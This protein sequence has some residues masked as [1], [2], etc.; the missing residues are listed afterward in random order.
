MRCEKCGAY[1][2]DSSNLKECLSCSVDLSWNSTAQGKTAKN[3]LKQENKR[4][5]FQVITPRGQKVKWQC[6]AS[7]EESAKKRLAEQGL[8]VLSLEKFERFGPNPEK[9]CAEVKT[10]KLK[11]SDV[12]SVLLGFGAYYFIPNMMKYYESGPAIFEIT[13]HLLIRTAV[14]I[15]LPVATTFLTYY[16]LK[17]STQHAVDI[18]FILGSIFIFITRLSSVYKSVTTNP[19][20]SEAQKFQMLIFQG[21]IAM[22]ISFG[23]FWISQQSIKWLKCLINKEK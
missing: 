7:D 12:I 17:K 6:E 11:L 4:F 8:T 19:A 5:V 23:I 10:N 3:N 1:N 14:F 16:L 21:M 13:L 20:L 22:I 18:S 2:P 15:V 9:T